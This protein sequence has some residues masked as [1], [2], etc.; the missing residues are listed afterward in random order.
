MDYNL[1]Y[2]I[3]DFVFKYHLRLLLRQKTPVQIRLGLPKHFTDAA[4][5]ETRVAF[6]FAIFPFLPCFSRLYQAVGYNLGYKI[7]KI[8]MWKLPNQTFGNLL[9]VGAAPEVA[10]P[11]PATAPAT[12]G[13]GGSVSGNKTSLKKSSRAL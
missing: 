3:I 8:L 12:Q 5:R 6:F 10:A 4:R 1:G 13:N 11:V 7:S 9:A 2:N